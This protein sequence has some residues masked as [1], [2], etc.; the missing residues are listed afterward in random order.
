MGRFFPEICGCENRESAPE[1]IWLYLFWVH[2]INIFRVAAYMQTF[3]VVGR[4]DSIV[5][6]CVVGIQG[7]FSYFYNEVREIIDENDESEP[8]LNMVNFNMGF[9]SY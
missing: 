2:G 9:T 8:C 7:C 3:T 4:G 5:Q 6:F 1:K